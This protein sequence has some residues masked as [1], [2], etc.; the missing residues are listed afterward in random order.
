MLAIKSYCLVSK[1]QQ[2]HCP[3]VRG[4]EITQ[5]M[6]NLHKTQVWTLKVGQVGDI[7][8]RP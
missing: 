2:D 1:S 8:K 7:Q 4:G 6:K 5:M 3:R